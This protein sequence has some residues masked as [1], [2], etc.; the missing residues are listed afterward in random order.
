MPQD[1]N[2]ARDLADA[3]ARVADQKKASEIVLLDVRGRHSLFDFFVVATAGSDRHAE[4]IGDEA[5]RWAK[6]E[7]LATRHVDVSPDWVCGDFGDVVLHV[8]TPEARAFYDLENLW[9]DA[10][11]VAFEA[12]SA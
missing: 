4:V 10:P 8:F 7:G 1:T 6:A 2:A 11:R 9:A 3:L 12:A 5:A